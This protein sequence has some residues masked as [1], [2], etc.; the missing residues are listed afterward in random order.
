MGAHDTKTNFGI[1]ILIFFLSFANVLLIAVTSIIW[2]VPPAAACHSF[3]PQICR[4][5]SW[6]WNTHIRTHRVSHNV[7]CSPARTKWKC[8]ERNL[9]HKC[10]TYHHPEYSSS[11]VGCTM[12][13]QWAILCTNNNNKKE[14]KRKEAL[15]TKASHCLL[16]LMVAC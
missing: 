9:I 1:H 16:P 12:A 7:H 13:L 3:S 10:T 4:T 2:K 15:Q 14:Q 8:F 6:A 11:L 5:S